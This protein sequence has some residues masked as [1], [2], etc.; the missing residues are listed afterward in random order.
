MPRKIG[1]NARRRIGP[2]SYGI[3]LAACSG[4]V[5]LSLEVLPLALTGSALLPCQALVAAAAL[6]AVAVLLDGRLADLNMRGGPLVSLFLGSA[7]MYAAGSLAGPDLLEAFPRE[8]RADLVLT[9]LVIWLRGIGMVVMLSV[10]FLALF[11]SSRSPG[12]DESRVARIAMAAVVAYPGVAAL[13][14]P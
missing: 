10:I 1:K 8:T 5:A 7:L 11:F 13:L 14:S 12:D 6:T 2:E 9:V 4:A 3:G